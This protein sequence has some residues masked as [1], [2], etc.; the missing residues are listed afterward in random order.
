MSLGEKIKNLRNAKGLTQ[1]GFANQF[2]ISNGTIAMWE[3]NK[4]QPDIN[5]LCKISNFFDVSVDYLVGNTD[6]P[7][8]ASAWTDEEKKFG[9]GNHGAK[10]SNDEWEVIELFSELKRVCG[11]TAVNAVKTIISTFIE[12]KEKG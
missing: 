8:K 4:R 7:R 5:T 2:Q 3:T 11:D 12:Q 1:I 6:D 10:L 9:V